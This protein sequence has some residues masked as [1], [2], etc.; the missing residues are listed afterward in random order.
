VDAY[1]GLSVLFEAQ[2]PK[3]GGAGGSDLHLKSIQWA[4]EE[5]ILF[6]LTESLDSD[7]I[8]PPPP[9]PPPAIDIKPPRSPR[10][11]PL[12]VDTLPKESTSFSFGEVSAES[13]AGYS[14]PGTTPGGSDP[15]LPGPLL[16]NGSRHGGKHVRRNS[17]EGQPESPHFFREAA[18]SRGRSALSGAAGAGAGAGEARL[19]P[20]LHL[21]PTLLVPGEGLLSFTH[22]PHTGS[23]LTGTQRSGRAVSICLCCAILCYAVLCYAVLCYAVLYCVVLCYAMLCYAVLYYAVLCCAVLCYA[24]LCYAVLCCA[25]LCY[26]VLCYAVLCYAMLCCTVL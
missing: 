3:A 12:R 20:P 2:T 11:S 13:A 22:S 25:M 17:K 8:L 18:D 15:M 23:S 14:T 16:S 21:D 24:M 19:V 10:P 7:G 5:G 6:K 26:A 1:N 4:L 9:P